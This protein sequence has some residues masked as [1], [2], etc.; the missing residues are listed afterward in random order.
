MRK[1]NN[2]QSST[3]NWIV[4]LQKIKNELNTNNHISLFKFFRDNNM[5]TLWGTFLLKSNIV[6]KQN[7]LYKWS[8]N[9]D[10]TTSLINRYR[11]Y[12]SEIYIK[13]KKDSKP[14]LFDMPQTPLPKPPKVTKTRIIKTDV[15]INNNSKTELGVIRRFLKWLW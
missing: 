13:G 4:S 10:V 1:A 11:K 2:R 6:Y 7:H 12:Q 9:I 15:S 5:N 3:K 8:E 14:T